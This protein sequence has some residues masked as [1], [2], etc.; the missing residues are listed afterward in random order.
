MKLTDKQ[1]MAIRCAYADLV[2]ALQAIEQNDPWKHDWEA[3][4]QSIYD[5]E[6][7]FG[8]IL[9]TPFYSESVEDED[10]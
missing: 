1:I 6:N 8:T 7:H 2:G 4:T 9:N 10:E 5:L 3:H